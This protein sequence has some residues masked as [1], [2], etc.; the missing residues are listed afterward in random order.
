MVQT[1]GT[2]RDHS[3][4]MTPLSGY[5]ATR[6]SS[7]SAV[8]ET[9][10]FSR[11][12]P[13]SVSALVQD[14]CPLTMAF[15]PQKLT[16]IGPCHFTDEAILRRVCAA[17]TVG[18]PTLG[19]VGFL[20]ARRCSCGEETSVQ[21]GDQTACVEKGGQTQLHVLARLT[22]DFDAIFLLIMFSVVLV[23]GVFVCVAFLSVVV[24]MW[25]VVMVLV[26]MLL[27][28]LGFVVAVAVVIVV[29]MSV[30]S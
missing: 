6:E 25:M 19:G 21:G 2:S 27:L 9:R 30:R 13:P 26:V 24:F 15:L 29:V 23:R 17:Q 12:R 22:R 5:K 1:F 14:L 3:F 11:I 20:Y 7:R 18:E 16:L 28:V 4:R 10:R 8:A